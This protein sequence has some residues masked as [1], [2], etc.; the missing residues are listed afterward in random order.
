L[1]L[2]YKGILMAG[3]AGSPSSPP[4]QGIP[5]Q[6][7]LREKRSID[8]CAANYQKISCMGS[9]WRGNCGAYALFDAGHIYMIFVNPELGE[10]QKNK[11]LT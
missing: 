5:R 4:R 9:R 3:L 10:E 8:F 1:L 11:D 2:L 6:D 7:S